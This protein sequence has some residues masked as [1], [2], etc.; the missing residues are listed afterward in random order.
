LTFLGIV[1]GQG[2]TGDQR[3]F[4]TTIAKPLALSAQ[5]YLPVAT[6][7]QGGRVDGSLTVSNP[8]GTAQ[9]IRLIPQGAPPGVTV[10]PASVSVSAASGSTVWPFS[11][12]LAPT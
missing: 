2:V 6:V 5:V 4:T 11:V 7:Q 12:H 3:T 1:A 10:S 8:T 9:K